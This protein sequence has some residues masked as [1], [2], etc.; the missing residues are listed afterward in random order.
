LALSFAV[1][2]AWR[3]ASWAG[4]SVSGFEWQPQ[5]RNSLNDALQRNKKKADPQK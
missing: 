1:G 5:I 3:Q 4:W 2:R